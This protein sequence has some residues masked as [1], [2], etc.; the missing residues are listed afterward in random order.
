[1]LIV[2][3]PVAPSPNQQKPEEEKEKIDVEVGA[4]GVV[5]VN[6]QPIAPVDTLHLKQCFQA[7]QTRA[8]NQ[9]PPLNLQSDAEALQKYVVAV[10]EA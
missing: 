2:D 1:M 7:E 3:P 10:R 9:D 5:T 6:K 8:G 4:N